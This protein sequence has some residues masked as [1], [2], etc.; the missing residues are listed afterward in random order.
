MGFK[1]FLLPKAVV[2]EDEKGLLKKLSLDD[3]KL[4][5]RIFTEDPALKEIECEE[6]NIIEFKST[7]PASD[8]EEVAYRI[9]VEA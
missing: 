6:G 9:V 8:A 4:L 5:P 3:K 7:N 1:H 2:V